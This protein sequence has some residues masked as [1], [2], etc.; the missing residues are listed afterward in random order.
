MGSGSSGSLTRRL[1]N[2]GCWTRP[3]CS[4]MVGHGPRTENG[5]LITAWTESA[6]ANGFWQLWIANASAGKP[7]MLDPAAVQSYG[8]AWSPD[9]EWI[10][11]YRLDGKRS[12]KWVLAALDR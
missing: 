10:A 11:Y 12:C 9:G 8:G 2:R 7:R 6:R 5:S 3:L 1:E 4:P